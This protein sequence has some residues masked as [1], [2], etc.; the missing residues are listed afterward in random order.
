MEKHL[1]VQDC[2]LHVMLSLTL[3]WQMWAGA[4]TAGNVRVL[5]AGSCNLLTL[6]L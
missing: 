4:S 2:T 1:G 5:P 3:H 6:S